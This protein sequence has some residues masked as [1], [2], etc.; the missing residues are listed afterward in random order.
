MAGIHRFRN[1]QADPA[2]KL[3][4]HYIRK[5]PPAFN[6]DGWPQEMSP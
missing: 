6:I 2:S 3:R 4:Y 1:G 5:G